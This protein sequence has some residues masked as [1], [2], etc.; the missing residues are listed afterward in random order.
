MTKNKAINKQKKHM[1]MERDM[2]LKTDKTGQSFVPYNH[3]LHQHDDDIKSKY[4]DRATDDLADEYGLNYYTVSRRATR[5]GVAK[6]DEFMRLSWKKGRRKWKIK[7][8]ERKQY[9]DSADTYLKEHFHDTSNEELATLFGVDVKTVRRWARRLGL[10]KSEEFMYRA[11]SKR[12]AGYYSDEQKAWR[13][14]RIADVYPDGDE[15]Q[16]QQ[17]AAELGISRSGL[18]RIASMS[19]IRRSRERVSQSIRLGHAKRWKGGPD[20]AAIAD[21]YHDHSN[22]ECAAKFGVPRGRVKYLARKNGWKKDMTYIYR[23]RIEQLRLC[24]EKKN[25]E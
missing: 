10:R 21:Y 6:S 16:L 5:L 14:R 15:E 1:T 25:M 18:N 13:E 3:W 7:G 23:L 9:K 17:L 24:R 19:G 2:E 11:R 22:E 4:R 12:R 8:E 20:T